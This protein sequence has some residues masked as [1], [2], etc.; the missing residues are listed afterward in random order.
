MTT[1]IRLRAQSIDPDLEALLYPSAAF[2]NPRDVLN[3]PDLTIYEKRAILSSWA[4]DVCAVASCPALRRPDALKKPIS[5]DEIM[6]A[7]K[8]LDDNDPPP[9]QGG[10][11]MRWGSGSQGPDLSGATL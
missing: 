3:D 5:F 2:N 4:S 6:E 8:S 7:L 9:R 1:N 11:S 10:K